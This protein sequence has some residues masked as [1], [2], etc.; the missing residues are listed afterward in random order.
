MTSSALQDNYIGGWGGITGSS[1]KERLTY[2]GRD[3]RSTSTGK[4]DSGIL[5]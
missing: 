3:G 1:E 5:D 4:E 2:I